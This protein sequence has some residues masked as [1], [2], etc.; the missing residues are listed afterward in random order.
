MPKNQP[1]TPSYRLHKPTGLAV[2]TVSGKDVYLGTYGTPESRAE[3]D[4]VVAE[5][6]ANGRRPTQ[7][8][9]A[10]PVSVS[11]VLL[12]YVDY[13]EA[14]YRPDGQPTKE[15]LH[16]KSIARHIHELSGWKAAP[17][18][19][20]DNASFGPGAVF[21]LSRY[22]PGP[23]GEL[24]EGTVADRSRPDS[25]KTFSS[26]GLPMIGHKA[27][28]GQGSGKGEV[29]D[30]ILLVS[31]LLSGDAWLIPPPGESTEDVVR[32]A[33][34]A[35]TGRADPFGMGRRVDLTRRHRAAMAEAR[36]WEEDYC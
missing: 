2:A 34:D 14:Y 5:W 15:L 8:D 20:P 22:A 9:R 30:G 18:P 36:T 33:I 17:N 29:A 27:P 12:A 4:R 1:R 26:W 24:Y 28:A 10:T 3:Y 25:I 31:T 32:S 16:I 23:S 35:L 19:S 7:E 21:D 13:A 11:E 6:L